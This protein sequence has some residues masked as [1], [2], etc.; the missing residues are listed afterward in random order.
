LLRL[1]AGQRVR[2]KT[3]LF[4][5]VVNHNLAGAATAL[6][7]GGVFDS[8]NWGGCG[9]RSRCRS[10]FA[11]NA[12]R[13]RQDRD[14]QRGTAVVFCVTTCI[15]V[16]TPIVAPGAK[17]PC[18]AVVPHEGIFCRRIFGCWR[19]FERIGDYLWRGFGEARFAINAPWPI[20]LTGTIL[21][22]WPILLTRAIFLTRPFFLTRAFFA[23]RTLFAVAAGTFAAAFTTLVPAIFAFA[24]GR[25]CGL[26]KAREIAGRGFFGHVFLN[27][28][29]AF[30]ALVTAQALLFLTGARIGQNAEV[31]V[32]KLKEILRLHTITIQVGIVRLLA[33]FFQQLRGVAAR[34]TVNAVDL[35]AIAAAVTTTTAA[36][37]TVV[38]PAPA[39]AVVTTNIVQ[40]GSFLNPVLPLGTCTGWQRRCSL[41][42]RSETGV[43]RRPVLALG[44]GDFAM[45]HRK[46]WD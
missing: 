45:F 20:F 5:S 1:V 11:R 6:G 37:R 43:L 23:A 32:S 4:R 29:A 7:R 35:L 15:P 22:A 31:M 17:T 12:D 33:I 42:R 14:I 41:N 16:G 46:F 9:F 30:P 2:R 44:H 34:A 39:P 28:V 27:L 10:L 19:C 25:V 21:T 38:V 24:A 40:G 3:G 26:V 8:Q 36:L 13:R 18:A